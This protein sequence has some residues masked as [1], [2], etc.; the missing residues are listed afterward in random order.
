MTARS[1]PCCDLLQPHDEHDNQ[2]GVDSVENDTGQMMPEGIYTPDG[3][4]YGMRYPSEGMPVAGVKIKES[5]PQKRQVDRANIWIIQNVFT[6]VPFCNETILE[7]SEIHCKSDYGNE[8]GKIV[9]KVS[10]FLHHDLHVATARNQVL[11]YPQQVIC[12]K[13][14]EIRT[15]VILIRAGNINFS[16]QNVF[17]SHQ[18]D[19]SN[20]SLA[21]SD[22]AVSGG[23]KIWR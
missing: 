3:I 13:N 4:V 19:A 11:A 23:G 21:S 22:R 9:S 12:R 10:L 14:R 7:S 6:V 17:S 18:S 1:S 2:K 15:R 5:P 8:T 20:N 16:N